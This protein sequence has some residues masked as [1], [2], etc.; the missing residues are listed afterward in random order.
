MSNSERFRF[1]FASVI[2][3]FQN[4]SRF[5]SI[6]RVEYSR[7]PMSTRF[8]IRLW[9]CFLPHLPSI[10]NH[11]SVQ[12]FPTASSLTSILDLVASRQRFTSS[13]IN[14]LLS[15]ILNVPALGPFVGNGYSY[16]VILPLSTFGFD[17]RIDFFSSLT[18]ALLLVDFR[19]VICVKRV[20]IGDCLRLCVRLLLR[21]WCP[22]S[23]VRLYNTLESNS[24]WAFSS[25]FRSRA[26]S[27]PARESQEP[28]RFFTRGARPR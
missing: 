1:I 7:S 6:L 16:V 8:I 15:I 14:T 3:C 12:G 21:P 27:R 5:R 13:Y 24:G 23:H 20:R 9:A 19:H 10:F 28:A 25:R 11:S 26:I 4:L 18:R 22:V 2:S 17:F